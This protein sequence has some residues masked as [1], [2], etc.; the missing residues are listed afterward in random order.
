MSIER[1]LPVKLVPYLLFGYHGWITHIPI[2]FINNSHKYKNLISGSYH[3]K[4]SENA[5][6]GS[7]N[8]NKNVFLTN[9]L[10]III[11]KDIPLICQ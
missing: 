9:F 3:K 4:Q 1:V 2:I 5:I 10:L 7:E 6:S 11:I 8:I